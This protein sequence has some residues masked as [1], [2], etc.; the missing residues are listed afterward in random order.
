VAS[1]AARRATPSVADTVHAPIGGAI[2]GPQSG[3]AVQ[4]Q[5][6]Q[7]DTEHEKRGRKAVDK[8]NKVIRASS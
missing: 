2:L 7:Q 1:G 6:A 4:A 3:P 8:N 5:Q